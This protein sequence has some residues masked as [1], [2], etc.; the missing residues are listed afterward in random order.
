MKTTIE[1]IAALR[2][3]ISALGA[4]RTPLESQVRSRAEVVALVKQRVANWQEAAVREA[5]RNVSLLAYGDYPTLLRAET[6]D[7]SSE[8]GYADLGPLMVAMMGAEQVC[9]FLLADING[10]PAGLD[11][12]DRVARIEAIGDELDHLEAEEE[13]LIEESEIEGQPIARR[14]NARPEIVLA[15]RP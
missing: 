14:S 5:A 9:A 10:V 1:Q 6:R 15:L 4:E 12:S 7:P 2:S 11:R 3:K 13:R 8:P